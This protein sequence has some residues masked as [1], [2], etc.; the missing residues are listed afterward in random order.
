MVW[1]PTQYQQGLAKRPAFLIFVFELNFVAAQNKHF[2]VFLFRL[3]LSL[4]R[5]LSGPEAQTSTTTTTTNNFW[6]SISLTSTA[7]NGKSARLTQ[8]DIRHGMH[9]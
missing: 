3:F 2:L 1:V 7:E 9:Y 5:S 8:I 6:K 4:S